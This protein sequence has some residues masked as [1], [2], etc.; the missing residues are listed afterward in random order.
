MVDV[1]SCGCQQKSDGMTVADLS[2]LSGR[3]LAFATL[4]RTGRLNPVLLYDDPT[5]LSLGPP[6][7]LARRV[8]RWAGAGPAV[9][10]MVLDG[11]ALGAENPSLW[12]ED[13]TLA[14]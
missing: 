6:G 12:A 3:M 5:A 11:A 10:Y 2:T 13:R 8:L 9:A 1:R 14:P 7:F 4:A